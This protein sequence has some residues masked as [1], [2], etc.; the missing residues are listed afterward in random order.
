MWGRGERRRSDCLDLKEHDES[1]NCKRKENMGREGHV[2]W[3][4]MSSCCLFGM[5]WFVFEVLNLKGK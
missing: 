4:W 2:Y 1:D 5:V 3:I